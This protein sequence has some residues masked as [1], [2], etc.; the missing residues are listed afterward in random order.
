ME[1]Q[2]NNGELVA[3][4]KDVQHNTPSFSVNNVE[5]DGIVFLT[6]TICV[7]VLVYMVYKLFVFKNNTDKYIDKRIDKK[8]VEYKKKVE[9][10]EEKPYVY[11]EEIDLK[12]VPMEKDIESLKQEQHT[13]R[14]DMKEFKKEMVD[15]KM[16]MV[17]MNSSLKMITSLAKNY[18]DKHNK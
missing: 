15:I 5:I 6:V 8:M 2:A 14:A 18:L 10:I 11:E 3:S 7:F 16:Q 13:A 4:V 1:L 9:E 12:I 17:E